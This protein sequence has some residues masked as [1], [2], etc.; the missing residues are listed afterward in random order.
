MVLEFSTE[1]LLLI[2][3]ALFF[4]SGKKPNMGYISPVNNI[5]CKRVGP[6]CVF[7][8]FCFVFPVVVCE[9]CLVVDANRSYHSVV[10]L[11]VVAVTW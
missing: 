10:V 2:A 1:S 5:I 11:R 8:R 9:E 3:T 7:K 6:I 4:T